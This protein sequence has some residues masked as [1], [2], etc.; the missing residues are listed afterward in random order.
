LWHTLIPVCG[1]QRQ[2]DPYEFEA[3]KVYRESSKTVRVTQRNF[4]FRGEKASI[5]KVSVTTQRFHKQQTLTAS[6]LFF[7]VDLWKSWGKVLILTLPLKEAGQPQIYFLLSWLKQEQSVRSQGWGWGRGIEMILGV[8]GCG[9]LRYSPCLS[10]KPLPWQQNGSVW[11]PKPWGGS[12][13]QQ[14]GSGAGA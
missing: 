5:I 13:I 10:S 11:T 9:L 7:E 3:N 4:C 2:D 6:M 14:S 8:A 12:I 1:R